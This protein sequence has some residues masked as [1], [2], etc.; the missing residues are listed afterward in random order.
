MEDSGKV[1]VLVTASSE[2]EARKIANLLLEHRKA[3]CVN[4]V[5]GVQSR[6]WWEDRLDSAKESLLIIKTRAALV[7]EITDIVKK[8]HSYTVPEIVAMP[9]VGGNK[10]YLDWVDQETG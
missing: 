1:V 2:E 3:A 7:P 5:A 6:F 8:A 10:D 9:I 4:L